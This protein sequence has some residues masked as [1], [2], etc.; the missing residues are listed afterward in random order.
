MQIQ[1]VLTAFQIMQPVRQVNAFKA[2]VSCFMRITVHILYI[3]LFYIFC[4][5]HILVFWNTFCIF[6]FVHIFILCIII[7]NILAFWHKA[8]VPFICVPL[9]NKMFIWHSIYYRMVYAVVPYAI[10]TITCP[11]VRAAYNKCITKLCKPVK[12]PF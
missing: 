5:V 7:Y 2:S 8:F 4:F 10:F 3:W 9:N 6:C 12:K 1:A 11:V